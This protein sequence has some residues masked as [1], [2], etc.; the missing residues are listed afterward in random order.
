MPLLHPLLAGPNRRRRTDMGRSPIH[1]TRLLRRLACAVPA[2]LVAVPALAQEG[3]SPV[4]LSSLGLQDSGADVILTIAA[5]GRPNCGDFMV[6]EPPTLVISC[7]GMSMGSLEPVT[8]VGTPT[9]DRL[10][11]A[12]SSDAQG[13]NTEL[14]VRLGAVLAYD[15]KVEG[16][17]LIVTLHKKEGEQPK[18]DAI[19]DAL[20]EAESKPAERAAGTPP[21]AKLR[22]E[23]TRTGELSSVAGE[24][25][26]EGAANQ[27]RGVDFQQDAQAGVSRLVLTA[28]SDMDY[29]T[30]YPSET[31][32]V[33]SI[34]DAA[35]G[36]GLERKID[37]SKFASAVDQIA[38]FRSR[39]VAGEVKIVVDMREA[40]T[41][42]ISQQG[43]V[44]LVD[45]PIPPSVAGATYETAPAVEAY[46]VPGD[47]GVVEEE[48]D[49][50]IESATARERIIDEGGIIR[51]PAKQARHRAKSIF[52]GEGVFLGEI[53]PN[54]QWRG[55]PI[56]LNLVSANIHNVFRLTSSVSKLNIVSSDDVE[57]TVTVQLNE[58][59]WDQA[60]A[61]ILQ[62]K[63]LGAVQYG[64]IIR[65]APIE[66][67]RKEREDAAAAKTAEEESLPLRVLTLPLN[68]A[69]AAE[70][71][72]QLEEML[73]KRG[74]AT[75]DERTNSLI[76]RDI[77]RNLTQVRQLVRA[78]DT[79]TP[80][81]HIEA[82]IVE[83]NQ[84][85]SRSLGI[86][87]GGNLNFS[88]ATGAPTGLFFP[89]S[90]G[91]SGG[92]TATT[93]SGTGAS[94]GG[95]P[96]NFTTQPN[97]VVDLPASQSATTLGVSLG[98]I[99]GMVNLDL[100]LSA[101]EATGTGRII[102]AP[103]ITTVTNRAAVIRDGARIPYETASLRGTNV[104]FVEAVLLLQVTP[105]ITAEGTIFLDVQIT[106]NRPDFANA[107]RN[108]P[109]IQIKE[110]KTT[111]MVNDGD[112]TV[113][114]GVYSFEESLNKT[115]VP[116]LGRIPV[117]G[118]LFKT[119]NKRTDRREL[120]VF[121][122]PTIVKQTN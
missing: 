59:P 58:V 83:A 40:V 45:F 64:N 2:L 120:L 54:H 6:S 60:L 72:K 81:V 107:V 114:G 36:T 102:S 94:Q 48:G 63:G 55:F 106:K 103:S 31:R 71:M 44:L 91:V 85:F 82:R 16:N 105:Q 92:N 22:I 47:D 84:A 56:N 108:L 80:Q 65:V 67:I 10:E 110:A 15:R 98:S 111:V 27:I 99:T 28:A 8:T 29:Q 96:T 23:S 112:T 24:H 117:L 86:Q 42:S 3:G 79:R 46:E 49:K 34:R 87:W 115:L 1:P 97:Y 11:L 77:D 19:A 62:A 52:G 70:V 104:E 73:S 119:T 89:N 21:P 12:E 7:A 61:A 38:A 116:G 66:T 14:R 109:T 17:A 50:P 51:D 122:T 69:A 118:W 25:T 41:P 121:I 68:Y 33:I 26:F 100:R 113:I 37:T 18:T 93:V 78:L 101:G 53:D 13:T 43:P 5:S 57:G 74:S 39:Q 30:S 90:I 75:F 95:R 32:L 9:V 4:T 35:L 76:I 88:P 20:G